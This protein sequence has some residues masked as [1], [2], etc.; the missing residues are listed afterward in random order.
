MLC[1]FD[2]RH[3]IILFS[4]KFDYLH[5]IFTVKIQANERAQEIEDEA[6]SK[7]GKFNNIQFMY[8]NKSQ[9][10]LLMLFE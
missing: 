10:S 2:A 5:I 1:R 3:Q 9:I 8:V 6:L 4:M 7:I